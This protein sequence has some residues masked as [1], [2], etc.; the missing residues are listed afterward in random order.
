MLCY[1]FG[2][3][4]ALIGRPIQRCLNFDER[5]KSHALINIKE[6]TSS[7]LTS[8]LIVSF[9]PN[10]NLSSRNKTKNKNNKDEEECLCDV[11]TKNVLCQLS[12]Y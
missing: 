8:P 1:T 2:E 3:T 12:S 7:S 9:W 4:S 6:G 11:H 5:N 10:G